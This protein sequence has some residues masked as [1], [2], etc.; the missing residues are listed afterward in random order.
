MMLGLSSHDTL[1]F[2]RLDADRQIRFCPRF[3]P[4]DRFVCGRI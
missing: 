1:A 2:T 4:G 3:L